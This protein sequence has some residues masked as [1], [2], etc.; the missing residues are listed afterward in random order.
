MKPVF[1]KTIFSSVLG[2]LCIVSSAQNADSLKKV[3]AHTRPDT[4]R[5]SVLVSLIDAIDQDSMTVYNE[6]LIGFC[7]QKL[8]TEQGKL[9][10][11][12]QKFLAEA[13]T[14]KGYLYRLDGNY[15]QALEY[16]DRS[17]KIQMA[18]NDSDGLATTIFNT[19]VVYQIQNDNVNALDYFT[20]SEKILEAMNDKK[21]L[22]E[23]YFSIGS[24]YNFQGNIPKALDYYSKSLRLAEEAGH[25]KVVAYSLNNIGS[26][27]SSQN[28]YVH[29]LEY[30]NKS[31]ALYEKNNDSIGMAIALDNIGGIY[32][33]EGNYEEALANFSRSYS[34]AAETGDK[35]ETANSLTNT[36]KVH[37]ERR[38]FPKALDCFTR[39]LKLQQ[40][41]GYKKGIANSLCNI[42][43]IY[44]EQKDYTKAET[45]GEQ[46][47]AI[48]KTIGFPQNILDAA[49]LLDNIYEAQGKPAKALEMYKLYIVMRDSVS[50]M[51]IQKA[52][53]R[54]EFE[55][56]YEKK[57]AADSIANA[58][59]KEIK[60]AEINQ[61]QAELRVKKNQQYALYGG[62]ALVL[63]F[64]GV[65]Y[66]RFKVTRKQNQI[67]RKQAEETQR[68]KSVVEEQK[69]L[70]EEKHKEI[71]DSIN[72]AERIQ[73]SFLASKS[74]LDE[75][76]SP[77][78]NTGAGHFVFF[79]PKAVVSGDFYWATLLGDGNF[80]YVT[81]DSTGHGVPGA[82]M[83][84]L[85]ISSLEK[86]AEKF[87]APSSILDEA[88]KT[89]IERL[90]KDGS[91]EGGKDGMDC[92]LVVIH[93]DKTRLT[94]AAANNP[95]WIVREQT[96]LEFSPDKMPVGKHDK[97]EVPFSQHTIDIQR[98]DVIY[99]LT[100]G[101]PDQFGGPSGKKFKYRQLKEKL[102]SIAHLPMH[103]QE[104]ALAEMTDSWQGELE[105]VDD[106]TII[107]VRIG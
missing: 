60:Q 6:K 62:L 52:S 87:S 16:Y 23:V 12:Y 63:I 99:T 105:Q 55:Y 71:T 36:G 106:I 65:M 88:R 74:L 32:E 86:A 77:P 75:H 57:A 47:L 54:R 59:E 40:E 82:I 10:S 58:K 41:I 31:L 102:V 46:S 8:Q 69:A 79:R 51:Q 84:I 94:Y 50:N 73:R 21:G 66:N 15:P 4:S 91:E 19:G 9:K 103:S 11:V 1:V 76:L 67:I 92:S 90:K 25:T 24:L 78:G 61:Q 97:D 42:G 43:K 72:Y 34:I 93:R 80:A 28:D 7:S 18:I 5:C 20:E 101:L 107:G 49:Q 89:I 22:S 30:Y 95:V 45:Y 100:D 83:S 44:F 35:K 13:Y 37:S 85:N 27:Y 81:A 17:R 64:A 48:S 14:T 2:L 56:N 98:G 53:L 3:L 104:K 38:D 68:Q 26:I 29:A 33:K 39:S 70:I 96:L